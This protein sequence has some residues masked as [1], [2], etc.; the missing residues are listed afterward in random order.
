[1][2]KNESLKEMMQHS[3][4]LKHKAW[5]VYNGSNKRIFSEI[6]IWIEVQAIEQ[7]N[8]GLHPHK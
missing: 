3:C 8:N 5:F 7:T 4:V 1:M 6:V 2:S